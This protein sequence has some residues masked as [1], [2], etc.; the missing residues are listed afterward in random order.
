MKK[1][2]TFKTEA[3]AIAWINSQCKHENRYIALN[4]K[5]QIQCYFCNKIFLNI[6]IK[7]N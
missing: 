1:D 7:T 3:E 5:G 2:K 6:K 4:P